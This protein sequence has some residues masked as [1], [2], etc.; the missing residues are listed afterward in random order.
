MI[1]LSAIV[2]YAT[3]ISNGT[4]ILR[5]FK[6]VTHIKIIL[7]QLWRVVIGSILPADFRKKQLR[8]GSLLQSLLIVGL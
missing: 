1:F 2:K 7:A 3:E 6:S 4:T 8:R 5:I